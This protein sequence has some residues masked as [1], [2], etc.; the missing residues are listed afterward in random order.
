M[1][2]SKPI[3]VMGTATMIVTITSV[4]R[5]NLSESKI[6]GTIV[7]I[8]DLK[9]NHPIQPWSTFDERNGEIKVSTSI[10]K[11]LYK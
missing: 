7:V 10:D 1:Q 9:K 6:N 3:A 8:S 11:A 5:Y 4:L 2:R